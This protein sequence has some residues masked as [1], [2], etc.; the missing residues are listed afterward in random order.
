ME[1][2]STDDLRILKVGYRTK[3]IKMIDEHLSKN[4][5]YEMG[6]RTAPL[7]A[8]K[9]ELLKLYGVGPATVW[10]LL[11]DVFHHWDHFDHISP[12]EQKI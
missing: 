2:V 1:N 3:S 8:Q 9:E 7:E 4:D 12:W 10:Y 11:F 6:L 5:F